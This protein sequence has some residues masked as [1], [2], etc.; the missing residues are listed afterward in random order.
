MFLWRSRTSRHLTLGAMVVMLAVSASC[1]RKSSG[2][3]TQPKPPETI[4]LWAWDRAEDL[5]FLKLEEADVAVLA[6]TIYLRNGEAVSRTRK[7]P[8]L[9]P[10]GLKP[11]AVVRL[12]SDGTS[13]P[14]ADSVANFISRWA[15]FERIQIDFDARLSQL[16]WYEELIRTSKR[17]KARISIT[18]LASWC[19]E[20]PWF[21]GIPDE[22]VPMLFQMGPQRNQV[23][24]RLRRHGGFAEGCRDIVGMSVAEPLVWRPEA[25]KIYVFNPQ[26]WTKEAFDEI[27]A[28]LR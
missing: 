27:C 1:G 28:R 8:L 9:L 10:D 4:V 26:R 3:A 24:D 11:M 5:R 21:R 20:K 16:T 6:E 25:K 18:A 12:E 14:P 17:M 22:A 23:L 2:S 15:R 13:L 19:L 7:L